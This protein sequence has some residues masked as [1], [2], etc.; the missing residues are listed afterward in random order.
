[1]ADIPHLV[2]N[3]GSAKPPALAA[4]R[5]QANV[6]MSSIVAVYSDALRAG[7]GSRSV[8]AGLCAALVVVSR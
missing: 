2:T 8:S 4:A 7:D 3:H 1:M 6:E 5:P